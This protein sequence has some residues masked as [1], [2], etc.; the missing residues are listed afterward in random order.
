MMFTPQDFVSKWKRVTTREKQTYQ[1]QFI[2]LC[3][4]VGHQTPSDDDPLDC[5][6]G[7]FQVKIRTYSSQKI[8]ISSLAALAGIEDPVSPRIVDSGCLALTGY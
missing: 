5:S 8:P 7:D 6:G 1:E 2:D 4:L 3:H